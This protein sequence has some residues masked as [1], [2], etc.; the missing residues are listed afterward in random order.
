MNMNQAKLINEV[1][2]SMNH[3]PMNEYEQGVAQ[4]IIDAQIEEAGMWD[5]CDAADEVINVRQQVVHVQS[6]DDSSV[7][8]VPYVAVTCS[9]TAQQLFHAVR[10]RNYKTYTNPLKWAQWHDEARYMAGVIISGVYCTA[11]DNQGE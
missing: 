5:A 7:V 9:H 11:E 8:C 3:A 1:L 6:D 2:A 10:E 4:R